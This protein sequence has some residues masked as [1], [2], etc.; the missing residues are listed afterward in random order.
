MRVLIVL[1][2]LICVVAAIV[3]LFE[4]EWGSAIFWAVVA[5]VLYHFDRKGAK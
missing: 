4:G 5:A 1:L 3:S 2:W